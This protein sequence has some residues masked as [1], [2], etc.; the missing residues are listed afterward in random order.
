MAPMLETVA[1][2]VAGKLAIGKIDC[3]S[4]KQLCKDFNIKGFPTLKYARDGDVQDF[5]FGRSQDDIVKFANLMNAPA[6]SPCDLH[7]D[8]L[9]LAT[10]DMNGIVFAVFHPDITGDDTRS[11]LMSTRL[12]QIFSQSARMQQAFATFCLLSP[13]A[14]LTPFGLVS[15]I[16]KEGFI[17]KL[18]AGGVPPKL[19]MGS[20][21]VTTPLV[22][23]FIQEY[24]VPLVA[25]LG[26][27]NFNKIGRQGK[28]PL[29]IGA[30][31]GSSSEQVEEMKQSL[32]HYCIH[33]PQDIVHKYNFGW[34]NGKQWNKFLLQF[35]ITAD[36]LPQVLVLDVPTKAYWHDPS[37]TDIGKFLQAVEDGTV[38]KREAASASGGGRLNQLVEL[39]FNFYPWSVAIL[40]ATLVLLILLILPAPEEMRPP[41]PRPQEEPAP[42]SQMNAAT[43]TEGAHYVPQG[44]ESTTSTT[45]PITTGD[46]K[47]ETKKEK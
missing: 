41:Y 28:K 16:P 12:T 26:P 46:G 20:N 44:E 25:T 11:R 14:D 34:I 37:H 24:N 38:E 42:L 17:V 23:D 10:A 9:Q 1:P 18:E 2:L 39:F 47:M 5:P 32:L 30:V 19:Y 7:Q 4:E 35:N 31:D 3:D 33:G 45:T 8:A 22:L 15:E 43:T 29:V 13:T 36:D 21:D 40:V 27:H 6:V